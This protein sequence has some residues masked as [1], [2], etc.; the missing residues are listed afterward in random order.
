[1]IANFNLLFICLFFYALPCSAQLN[2]SFDDGDIRKH[3]VWVG[4]TSNFEI[5]ANGHLHLN[6]PAVS[7]KSWIATNSAISTFAE[8]R[9][10]LQLDFNPSSSNYVKVYLMADHAHPDS[11]LNGYYLLIG[12]TSDNISLYSQSG[13]TS[14][15]LWNSRTG[16]L[17]ASINK[18][19]IKVNRSGTGE[20][21]VSADSTGDVNYLPLG[22]IIDS[23]FWSSRYFVVQCVYTSTRSNKF[24]FDDFVVSGKASLDTIPPRLLEFKAVDDSVVQLNFAE[25]IDPKS[26]T[27]LENYKLTSDFAVKEITV[28]NEKIAL[29]HLSKP[30]SCAR[31]KMD[32]TGLK[33]IAGNM[34]KDTSISVSYCPGETFEVL[35]TEIM[36]DPD[37]QVKLPDVEYLELYNRGNS[38]LDLENWTLQLGSDI[39]KLPKFSL[40][41]DSLLILC[42]SK[43]C[44]NFGKSC[45]DILSTYS[46]NNS[47]EYIGLKNARGKLIHWV[48][49]SDEWYKDDLKKPGGW[50][51]EMIDT[52]D[53]CSGEVNWKASTDWRGG[54]PGLKNPVNGSIADNLI[55][56]YEKIFLPNDSTVRLYFNK[57]LD[58][59]VLV[60]DWFQVD[61]DKGIP[62]KLT[63]DELEHA[64]VDLVFKS[65]FNKGTTY[66]LLV[67]P[68]LRCCNGSELEQQLVIPFSIPLLV[69]KGDIIMNEVLFDALP[70]TQEFVE[71]YNQSNKFLKSSDIKF[72]Y[73]AAGGDYASTYS[74]GSYPFLIAPKSFVVAAKSTEGFKEHYDIP[75][76]H[77]LNNVESF[78]ALSNEEGCVAIMNT[79]LE[80]LDEFCYSA[81]MHMPVLVNKSG[82]SLERIRCNNPT[83]DPTNWHSAAS[84]S[85]F[86]TPGA[87]NSQYMDE[88]S[89]VS[90]LSLEYEIFS[91]DNDGYKDV[92]VIHYK[93]D[94]PGYLANIMVFDATGRRVRLIANNKPIGTEGSFSWDGIEDDGRM[95]ATGIYLIYSE[96]HHISGTVKK[97]KN[98]C[99]LGGELKK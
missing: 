52:A 2:D 53:P 90:E 64:F 75:D 15:H 55:F 87:Q 33:D 61:K 24:S 41:A 76:W 10:W 94:Q 91:P 99:V 25:N 13:L 88:G 49:Y 37:P 45:L 44:D 95:A 1:M 46:L 47:G 93:L 43:G 17:N 84:T 56:D 82:V 40:A 78:P 26:L 65:A 38:T 32:I 11:A 83:Q 62:V 63:V 8:W 4:D 50:S 57:A 36:A 72:S 28:N 74:L 7:G 31:Q 23:T 34:M 21:S 66:N 18:L 3:P 69:E 68:S 89:S 5:N 96:L 51:L 85:N 73:H 19:S 35:I 71:I 77:S 39:K 42:T 86:A 16:I 58:T 9:F 6:A 67:S 14:K 54:S 98:T 92:E 79:G 12:G 59:E 60:R 97:F 20:W 27:T 80:V 29:L 81:K 48:H 70:G 22:S 30:L